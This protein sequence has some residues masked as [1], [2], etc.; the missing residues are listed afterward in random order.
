MKTCRYILIL[1]L[2]ILLITATCFFINDIW[3]YVL[4]YFIGLLT[5]YFT[6][7][8][9][10]FFNW[11]FCAFG[12]PLILILGIGPIILVIAIPFFTI[13][14]IG[15]FVYA[16]FNYIIPFLF[17]INLHPDLISYLLFTFTSILSV[18]SITEKTVNRVLKYLYKDKK[19]I[20]V[21]DSWYYPG[22]TRFAI[23]LLYFII[24]LFNN[25][26]KYGNSDFNISTL[27]II[28]SSFATF[29]AFDRLISNW[30]MVSSINVTNIKEKV[31][32]Y[33]KSLFNYK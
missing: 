3:K 30:K 24:L 29:L 7:T 19:F 33:I 22:I 23:F 8:D 26:S 12:F 10:K 31:F 15:F 11:L 17:Q 18:L 20:K 4:V 2:G 32:Q 28:F 13:L 21:F 9:S 14:V 5:T 1:A 16:I 27:G 25:I 6:S